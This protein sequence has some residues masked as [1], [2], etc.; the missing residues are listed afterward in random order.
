MLDDF[1][2]RKHGK[3]KVTYMH[4]QLET[5]LKKTYGVIVYQ[6][7]VMQIANRLAGFSLAQADLLRRAMGK[8]KAGGDGA[9]ED[10]LHGG[11]REEQRS[12]EEGRRD[13]R[14]HG[15]VRGLRLRALAQRGLRDALL[16]VGV[17]QGAHAAAYL[18][19]S[20]TSEAGT[21]TAS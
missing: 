17:A 14:S 3:Q 2:K 21:R 13:L 10:G 15:E 19:A 6:D 18:A 8:K 20:L 4:P 5:L 9:S 12:G 11:L 1:A 16:S 7:Q